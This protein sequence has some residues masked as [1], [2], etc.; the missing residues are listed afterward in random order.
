MDIGPLSLAIDKQG[1]LCATLDKSTVF[2]LTEVRP[3]FERHCIKFFVA[4]IG[5]L[6][7]SL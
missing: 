5:P 6:G 1:Y 4:G 7:S 3:L 2:T